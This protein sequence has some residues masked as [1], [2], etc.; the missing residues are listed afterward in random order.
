MSTIGK[1][2]E[3][4]YSAQEVSLGRF[5]AFCEH[6]EPKEVVQSSGYDHFYK[7]KKDD[8]SFCRHRQGND[9]NQLTFKRK[10]T[11]KNNVVRTERNL[12]LETKVSAEEVEALCE[13]FGYEYNS[14]IFKNIF[15]YIYDRYVLAY[16]VVYDTNLKELGRFFEIEASETAEWLSEE[17]ALDY[18]REVEQDV[19]QTLKVTPQNRIRRSLFEMFG[20]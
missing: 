4:K 6:R 7:S 17:K 18:I 5:K 14:T 1:E 19:T 10:L 9:L 13:E 15:V 8:A 20:E 12:S 2:I 16:Y 3:Y 11:E